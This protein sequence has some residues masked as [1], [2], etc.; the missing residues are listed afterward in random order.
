MP[1]RRRTCLFPNTACSWLALAGLLAAAPLGAA[2]AG[3][4]ELGEITVSAGDHDRRGTPV[5]HDLPPALAEALATRD[6]ELRGKGPRIALQRLPDGRGAFVLPRLG[7]GQNATY[8]LVSRPRKASAAA[9]VVEEDPDGAGLWVRLG[10]NKAFRYQALARPPRPDIDSAYLRGGYIHPVLS[11]RGTVVTDDYPEDHKHQHGIFTAWT[12]TEY[13]GRAPDFWNMGQKKARK[14]HVSLE[15]TFGGPVAGGFRARLGSTDLGATPPKVVLDERW[16]VTLYRTH[17][18]RPPHFLFDLEWTDEVQGNSPLVL[19]DYR[20]G[21]L[22]VR[23]SADWVDPEKVVF[24]TSE[25]KDR[26]SGEATRPRWSHLGG[27]VG[28]RVAGIAALDHPGNFRAPQPV[29]IHP[30][31]PYFS[32]APQK[33]GPFELVP[34]KPY[35]SRYRFVVSDGPV[36]RAL[37]D[38]LWNDYAHPPEVTVRLSGA[39][40]G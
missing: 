1:S 22:G 36:D 14:D 15:G 28:K 24:S 13:E 4:E 40:S 27:Q 11:P 17:P 6:I 33:A 35:V 20:Y 7:K 18:G 12:K 30:K 32:L 8:R 16:M 21:G 2:P 23:G 9:V 34:G 19:P 37:L 31:D 25:G 26:K 29:R 10:K 3:A 5:T 39:R 38:R